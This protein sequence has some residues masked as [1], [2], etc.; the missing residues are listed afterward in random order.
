[1]NHQKEFLEGG[2]IVNTH[3]IKG[4]VKIDSWCDTPEVLANIKTIYIDGA[5]RRVRSARVHK[6]CVIAFL[7]GVDDVNAAMTLKGKIIQV[8]RSSIKLPEG[9]VFMADLVGL[10]VLDADSGVELGILADVL[11]PSVQ[12]VYVVHG[13]REILIP[14]VDEFIDEIN[15]D[16]G[17]IKVRLIEGM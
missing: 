12:K 7:E 10:K 15:V 9:Q 4:E 5:P 6:N 14:A 2:Q 11:A 8:A 16:G 3:G 17:Y 13:K 1:M